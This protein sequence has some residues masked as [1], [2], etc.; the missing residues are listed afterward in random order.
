MVLN[1]VRFDAKSNAKWCKMQY[2]MLLNAR[3]K[4]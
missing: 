3:R 1:A 4:A 2:E